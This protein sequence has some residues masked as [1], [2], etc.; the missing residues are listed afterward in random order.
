MPYYR[1]KRASHRG[2]TISLSL[3]CMLLIAVGGWLF[4]KSASAGAP[5]FST[6]A[7]DIDPAAKKGA[8]PGSPAK[9][10]SPGENLFGYRIL[11]TPVFSTDGYQGSLQL[12]N[13]SFNRY[14]AVV[15]LCQADSPAVV[16]RSRYLPPGYYIDKITLSEPLAV[17]EYPFTAYL[18]LI[19]PHTFQVVDI[20]ECPLTVTIQA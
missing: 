14:W 11:S 9:E 20:L 4:W 18:S 7:Q 17:G 8:L 12:E 1:R 3:F 2:L 5:V 13:P 16:Y 15:E 19:D 6:L 10:R